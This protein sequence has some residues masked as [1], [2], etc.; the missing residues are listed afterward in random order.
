MVMV[1]LHCHLLPGIDPRQIDK[2]LYQLSW[3][4]IVQRMQK[5]TVGAFAEIREQPL[6]QRRFIQRWLQVNFQP[7]GF[8]SE[9]PH[10]RRGGQDHRTT[11]AKVSKQHLSKVAVNFFIVFIFGLVSSHNILRIVS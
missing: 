7:V 5:I 8:P 6:V 4:Q 10:V 1:D 3:Q 9:V 11:Y 2:R